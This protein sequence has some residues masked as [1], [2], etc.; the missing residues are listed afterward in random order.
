MQVVR[1][2]SG[3]T[4]CVVSAAGRD[5]AP[6]LPSG[7]TLRGD[8]LISP[9]GARIV[10]VDTAG[11]Y[12]VCTITAPTCRPLPGARDGDVVSGWSTD[13][14]SVFVFQPQPMLAQIEKIDV[15]SGRRSTWKTVR[16]LN[17]AVTGFRALMVAPDGAVAYSY[18]RSRSELYVIK[19]LK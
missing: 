2:G 19:G 4:V 9:D 7:A 5:P 18:G 8:N 15:G 13:G 6:L 3:P 10:A 11:R 12:V 14:Q 17:P 1:P 16:P